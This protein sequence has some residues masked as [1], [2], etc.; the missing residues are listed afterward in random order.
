[1]NPTTSI[2]MSDLV[3]PAPSNSTARSLGAG[4]RQHGALA[5]PYGLTQS[6]ESRTSHADWASKSSLLRCR[7]LGSRHRDCRFSW[8]AAQSRSHN[9][10]RLGRR[11]GCLFVRPELWSGTSA[12]SRR[13]AT[14]GLHES[15][16]DCIVANGWDRCLSRTLVPRAG[17]S[18][19]LLARSNSRRN[20]SS[21][22]RRAR[23]TERLDRALSDAA[24]Q[25][26]QTAMAKPR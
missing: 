5:P 14:H 26:N 24:A 2:T 17:A 21:A 18:R 23:S 19:M 20:E 25:K 7:L 22:G 3:A 6:Q 16:R 10:W 1:M 9:P 8:P 12:P 4:S 15:P 13:A 11:R